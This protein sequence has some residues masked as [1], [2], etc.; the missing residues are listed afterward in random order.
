MHSTQPDRDAQAEL[1]AALE[2]GIVAAVKQGSLEI[3][4]EEV[5]KV[6][7]WLKRTRLCGPTVCA[8]PAG[9][10]MYCLTDCSCCIRRDSELQALKAH[11]R[12]IV[13]L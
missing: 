6:D 3:L 8:V 10:G 7:S 2:E 13:D 4:V 5:P 9:H 1:D 11:I 12:V